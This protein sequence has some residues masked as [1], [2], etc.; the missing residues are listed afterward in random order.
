MRSVRRSRLHDHGL[1]ATVGLLMLLGLVV[2]YTISPVLN[3]SA[4]GGQG[5]NYFLYQ[6]L[7]KSAFAIV[8]FVIA[9]K[10]P[11]SWWKRALPYMIGLCALM[12]VL[13]LIPQTSLTL[14]GATRWIDL[15]F[16]SFQPAE[17]VKLT[18]IMYLAFL[19]GTRS[20][21]QLADPKETLLPVSLLLLALGVYM[22]VV[23]SD[24][25]TMLVLAMVIVGMLYFRGLPLRQL[26]ALC[27]TLLGLGVAAVVMFPYRLE[28]LTTFLN[29]EGS[30]QDAGYHVDQAL[31][32]I[33]SGGLLGQGLGRS[34]QVYGF[35]PEAENDS[36]F[37]IYGEIFG[38]LGATVLVITFGV[39]LWRLL[40]IAEKQQ[41]QPA[42]LIVAGIFLWF[43]AH[44]LIN[45]GAML[46]LMPLT[47]ITLPFLS[48][49]GSSL[50]MMMIALGVAYRLSGREQ[51][52]VPTPGSK[53]ISFRHRG[54]EGSV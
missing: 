52:V 32:A 47:G 17:F 6:H 2:I 45:I 16:F 53:R 48:Y 24:L 26:G 38:F 50:L 3:Y 44:I 31:T 19:I 42:R 35:L 34:V 41:Q 27:G 39:L 25:G 22:T 43:F 36:V 12:F 1:V 49:G 7:M 30:L 33:G 4:L 46:S 40:K 20:D 21:K 28:R 13:L 9:S 51:E 54:T 23:Q 10:L 5:S 18:V 11:L 37:A 29:P 8:A 14:N 15:G